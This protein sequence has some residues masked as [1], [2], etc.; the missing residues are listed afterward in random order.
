MAKDKRTGKKRSGS[1]S[2]RADVTVKLLPEAVQMLKEIKAIMKK[3]KR[4][5]T[6]TYSEA[7]EEM[8][9]IYMKN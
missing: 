7:I 8:Y 6:P 9:E 5:S 1:N 4:A 2:R 3:N